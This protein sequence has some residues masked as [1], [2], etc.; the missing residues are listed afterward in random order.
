M[1]LGYG[2]DSIGITPIIK[3]IA[4]SSF[5]LATGG[6]CLLMLAFLYWWI[7][8]LKHKKYI[9]FFVIVGMNSIFIYLFCQVLVGGWLRDYTY[10]IV[11]NILGYISVNQGISLLV[12]AIILF[13]IEW[14]LCYWLYKKKIFFKV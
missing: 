8:V 1:I 4:T 5:T 13:G 12:A 3:R 10:T 14:Y 6:W 2:L 7:D 11:T 9:T